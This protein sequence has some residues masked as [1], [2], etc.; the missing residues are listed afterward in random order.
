[1]LRDNRHVTSADSTSW[2]QG[3]KYGSISDGKKKAHVDEFSP[4][5]FQERQEM[6]KVLLAGRGLEFNPK[7]LRYTTNAS[8]RATICKQRYEVNAGSQ[9]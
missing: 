7:M 3:V 8:I 4:A 5:L 2:L 6:I 1:M 9:E